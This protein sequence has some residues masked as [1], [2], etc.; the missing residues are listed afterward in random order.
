MRNNIV[1]IVILSTLL[2]AGCGADSDITS[3]QSSET[4]RK[5]ARSSSP[6]A[7]QL[8]QI[9]RVT[10]DEVGDVDAAILALSDEEVDTWYPVLCELNTF[11]TESDIRS[12]V[13][14]NQ[15]E[16]VEAIEHINS[17]PP[18]IRLLGY[19]QPRSFLNESAQSS[20]DSQVPDRCWENGRE[21]VSLTGQ[22]LST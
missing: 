17:A 19:Q 16:K 2:L 7:S 21:P 13:E 18:V 12:I 15:Q 22:D 11:P 5:S 8:P 20:P 6:D 10:A 4:S 1:S 14:M 3:S 9:K